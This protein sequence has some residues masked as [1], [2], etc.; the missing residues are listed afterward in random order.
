MKRR[1]LLLTLTAAALT[2]PAAAQ[3]GAPT[4]FADAFA[5]DTSDRTDLPFDAGVVALADPARRSLDAVPARRAVR[6]GTPVP[7]T[8]PS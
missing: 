4:D 8:P 6:P 1:A 7:G 2:V 3:D 5:V